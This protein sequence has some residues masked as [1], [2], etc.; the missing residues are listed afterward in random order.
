MGHQ[1]V[2][3]KQEVLSCKSPWLN[4]STRKE[5]SQVAGASPGL[6]GFTATAAARLTWL[7]VQG[8]LYNRHNPSLSGQ[9]PLQNP[10]PHGHRPR[11]STSKNDHQVWQGWAL[12]RHSRPPQEWACEQIESVCWWAEAINC[13]TGTHRCLFLKSPNRPISML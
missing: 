1:W 13:V 12:G 11:S 2:C 6:H 9:R 10:N 5:H 4:R 3:T 7:V 8:L